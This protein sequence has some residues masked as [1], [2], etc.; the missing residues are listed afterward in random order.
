[1][2]HAILGLLV[3][4]KVSVAQ[5]PAPLITG[6]PGEEL[7]HSMVSADFDGDG[8]IDIAVSAPRH[9]LEGTYTNSGR[10][11]IVRGG[12]GDLSERQAQ[13]NARDGNCRFGASLGIGDLNGDRAP[14]LL[15]GAPGSDRARGEA[16][17]LRGGKGDGEAAFGGD[18]RQAEV[19]LSIKGI[20]ELGGFGSSIAVGDLNGD[21]LAEL[22]VG[23]SGVSVGTTKNSGRVWVFA[24]RKA[25][26]SGTASLPGEGELAASLVIVGREGDSLGGR[27]LAEDVNGDGISDLVCSGITGTHAGV[28]ESGAVFIWMGKKDLLSNSTLVLGKDEADY[29]VFG[30]GAGNLGF[31]LASLDFDGDGKKELLISEPKRSVKGVKECG[32]VHAVSIGRI[33]PKCDLGAAELAGVV[34]RFGMAPHEG[35]GSSIWV[36]V[37]GGE[38]D[39]DLVI[40][41]ASAGR[42]ILLEDPADLLLKESRAVVG[43]GNARGFGTSAVF[44]KDE[45]DGPGHLFVGAPAGV[46]VFRY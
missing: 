17:V 34:S 20:Q 21:G 26:K 5:P 46:K 1:M 18:L 14:D 4:A 19:F 44:A 36:G 45:K 13:W 8:L 30:K 12:K 25:W 29:V 6:I 43:P 11:L 3:A 33:G 22:I 24:G 9:Q 15:V 41:A 7:G 39:L 2:R 10:V 40:G 23:E 16:F 38:P 35:F 28:P 32:A 37:A 27:V 42:V 31:A